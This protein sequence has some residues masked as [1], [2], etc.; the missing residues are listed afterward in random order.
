[1]PASDLSPGLR[2]RKKAR[3]RLAIRREAF[4][5]FDAQ[6]F[7][8]TTVDQIAAAADVSPRT[9]YRYFSVKEAVLLS[10]DLTTPIVEAFVRAPPGMAPVAA[11]RYAVQKVAGALTP[12]QR[13]DAI[14]GQQMLYAIPEARGLL[15]TEYVRL[16]HLVTKALGS[17]GGDP[18]DVLERRVIAGAI[19]GV[20]IASSDNTPLPEVETLSA[21]DVLETKLRFR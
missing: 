16:I 4:R 19:V 8:D 6:G 13:Q 1:M 3:T 15:Y 7:R 5:L 17:R 18:A 9:F 14:A 11:Y 21:L 2:E 10:D 20:L 12:E